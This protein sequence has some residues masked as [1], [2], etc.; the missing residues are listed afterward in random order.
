M[1]VGLMWLGL[2][3]YVVLNFGSVVSVVCDVL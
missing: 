3:W 2:C 1:S